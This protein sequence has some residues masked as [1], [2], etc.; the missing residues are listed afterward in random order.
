MPHSKPH[1]HQLRR[2]WPAKPPK[3]APTLAELLQR[4]ETSPDD[5]HAWSSLAHFCAKKGNIQEGLAHW[6]Q[7]VARN[8][9]N[10]EFLYQ[11]A[12]YLFVHGH[13]AQAVAAIEPVVQGLIDARSPLMR[14]KDKDQ[15]KRS[16]A[17]VALLAVA[18]DSNSPVLRKAYETI[19]DSQLQQPLYDLMEKLLEN[20]TRK[21]TERAM[22]SAPVPT[23][24]DYATAQPWGL[25]LTGPA[26]Q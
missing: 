19:I 17:C 11:R 10:I 9:G 20:S 15:F 5:E 23:S 12:K 25:P 22:E 16:M 6:D 2:S 21:R 24:R 13:E 8:P 26:R 14:I 4:V 3:P 7:S 1:F 18:S